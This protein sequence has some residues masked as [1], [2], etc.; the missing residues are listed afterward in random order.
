MT[1]IRVT[2]TSPSCS[3][4][5]RACWEYV[6]KECDGCHR[7]DEPHAHKMSRRQA[8]LPWDLLLAAEAKSLGLA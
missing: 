4:E 8:E 7:S 1:G 3:D 2:T 6:V 5:L